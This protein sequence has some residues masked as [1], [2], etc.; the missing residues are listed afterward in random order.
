VGQETR[1]FSVPA[2][3]A[4]RYLTALP[5]A[6]NYSK[7]SRTPVVLVAAPVKTQGAFEAGTPQTL[8][9]AGNGAYIPSPDGQRFLVVVPAGGEA[10]Q[11]PSL[12]VVT[13]WQAGLKK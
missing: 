4:P 1:L 13:N 3:W 5:S 9:E 12:T 8:F 6:P 2:I 10:A 7:R 11:A